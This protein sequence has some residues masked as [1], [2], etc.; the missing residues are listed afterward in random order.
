QVFLGAGNQAPCP[1]PNPSPPCREGSVSHPASHVIAIVRIPSRWDAPRDASS[2][3][4]QPRS[5]IPCANGCR[6]I[7][8]QCFLS[9][10]L[11]RNLEAHCCRFE[12]PTEISPA[13]V[14]HSSMAGQ[15]IRSRTWPLLL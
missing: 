12:C 1:R 8:P 11:Y 5:E 4:V 9:D 6:F 3:V 10:D 13:V 7:V 14:L 15:H 2:F